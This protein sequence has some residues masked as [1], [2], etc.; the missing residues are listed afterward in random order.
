MIG[1][2]FMSHVHCLSAPYRDSVMAGLKMLE[3]FVL[4][5]FSLYAASV[6]SAD[7]ILVG[8][9]GFVKSDVELD[10]SLVEVRL[11]FVLYRDIARAG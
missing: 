9:G 2:A 11:R 10:Y 5:I 3:R 7:D 4:I 6:N 8:C 1:S